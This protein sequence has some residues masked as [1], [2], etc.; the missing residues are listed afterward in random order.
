LIFHWWKYGTNV[1]I[2]DGDSISGMEETMM[3]L[4]L[5][6]EELRALT[7][8]LENYLSDL[9]MEISDTDSMDYRTA[10]K[11]RKEVLTNILETLQRTESFSS[12]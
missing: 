6:E 9:R 5:S 3:H 10:L 1:E 4:N 2:R 8:V 12:K 7:G 11:E